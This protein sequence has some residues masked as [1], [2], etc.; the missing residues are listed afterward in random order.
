MSPPSPPAPYFVYILSCADGTLYVG[1]TSDLARRE[2]MHNDGRGA[3]YT[4][5]RRPVRIAYS[6]VH[7]SRSAAQ[8]R[9]AELKRWPR[10]R[11]LA[12]FPPSP[13]TR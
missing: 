5:G 2:R 3:K 7:E 8:R 12:L 10:S 6:E 11:K 13:A 9:E 4:A 1:S